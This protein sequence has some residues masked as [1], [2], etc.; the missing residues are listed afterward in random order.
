MTFARF[1]GRLVSTIEDYPRNFWTIV[2]VT[3]IDRLGGALLFPFFTL[4]ITQKF[5]V[6]MTTVGVMFGIFAV[7]GMVGSTIGGA[8]TDR[9]GRKTMLLFG[10][11]FS[12]VSTL[13]MGLVNELDLF[14]AG[15]VVVGL[16]SNVGG[17]AQQAMVA[18]ILPEEQ[19]AQ[20]FGILR[21]VMNLSVTLGPAI[22]GLLAARSYLLLFISDT[23]TSLIVAGIVFVILPE[24]RPIWPGSKPQESFAL[25]F[26]GYGRVLRDK[27]FMIFMGASI[28]MVT[29]YVQMNST[30]AVYLHDVHSVTE[31]G[32]G[33]ILSMNALM[34]VLFQF[35]ITR[36]ITRYPPL[37]I[38]ALASALYAFG[39][40]MYGFASTYGSFLLAM[41]IIT[42]GE[43]FHV[44]V[45]QALVAK[46]APEDF[47]GR[48]MAVN[49]YSW[50]IPFA[51]GPLLA[52]LIMDNADPRWVWYAAGLVGLAATSIFTTLYRRESQLEE[53]AVTPS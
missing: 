25:T 48:Y 28:L 4:Y 22:G 2:V 26:A 24:T 19:R 7:T 53:A 20:G 18:D 16:L 5:G 44:P 52:G 29:V 9:I 45:S 30:L 32:F 31:Q 37:A 51:I 3:F 21:V 46:M 43:M 1:R 17:P 10:L 14:M 33:Y 27:F 39:F 40:A 41:V 15:T 34:V 6:G 50:A 13:W 49:G 42:I 8:L 47:R 36:R 38:M 12:A 35:P 11:I 23:V